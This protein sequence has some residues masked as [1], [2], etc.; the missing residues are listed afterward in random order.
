MSPLW[1]PHRTTT[2]ESCRSCRCFQELLEEPAETGPRESELRVDPLIQNLSAKSPAL[3]LPL[4]ALQGQLMM[5]CAPLGR[6]GLRGGP[7]PQALGVSPHAPTPHTPRCRALPAWTLR[8]QLR[9]S[10]WGLGKLLA[11][12][13]GVVLAEVGACLPTSCPPSRHALERAPRRAQPACS[14]SF[15]LAALVIAPPGQR[16]SRGEPSPAGLRLWGSSAGVPGKGGAQAVAAAV[17]AARGVSRHLRFT[18]E[19]GSPLVVSAAAP[20]P[21]LSCSG[22]LQTITASHESPASQPGGRLAS[23]DSVSP[24]FS[25]RARSACS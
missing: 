3:S 18:G 16:H 6:C 11:V 15:L 22:R 23:D 13:H 24:L 10:Q 20:S 7:Q 14:S 4:E 1:L 5:R 9:T 12:L 8:S 21:E 19:Q 17:S 2:N 25:P